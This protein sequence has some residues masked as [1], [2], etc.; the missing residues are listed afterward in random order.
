M[1]DN[2]AEAVREAQE[3]AES[4]FEARVIEA[5]EKDTKGLKEANQ[6]LVNDWSQ[7]YSA[8]ETRC[9][10][11]KDE[12]EAAL[13]LEAKV[14]SHIYA[15]KWRSQTGQ[16]MFNIKS[17]GNHKVIATSERYHNEKDCDDTIAL[18]NPRETK[19]KA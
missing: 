10:E 7:K 19:I 14:E 2:Q 4:K 16:W 6:K 1:A 9:S 18:F 12:L 5:V 11:L 3:E 17:G 13:N 15:E 8:L